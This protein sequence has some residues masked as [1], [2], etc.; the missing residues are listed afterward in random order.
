MIGNC[1]KGKR[2]ER[3]RVIAQVEGELRNH[4]QTQVDRNEFRGTSNDADSAEGI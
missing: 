4:V 3:E 2:T 1:P